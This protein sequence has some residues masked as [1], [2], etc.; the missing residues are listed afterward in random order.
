M[1]KGETYED[2]AKRE[3]KE[4]LGVVLPVTMAEKFLLSTRMKRNRCSI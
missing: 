1:S 4:E 2:A 3:T